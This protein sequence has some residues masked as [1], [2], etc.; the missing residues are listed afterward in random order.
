MDAQ[1]VPAWMGMQWCRDCGQK[2]RMT[3]AHFV[4]TA[5]NNKLCE[6][7]MNTRAALHVALALPFFKGAW[8]LVRTIA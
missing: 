7:V 4:A 8:L 2:L 6:L 5:T 3:A 1:R